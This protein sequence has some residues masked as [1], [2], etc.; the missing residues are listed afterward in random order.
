MRDLLGQVC[1]TQPHAKLPG[2]KVLREVGVPGRAGPCEEPGRLSA[3]HCGT[4]CRRPRL[5]LSSGGAIDDAFDCARHALDT[6]SKREE[7]IIANYG[8]DRLGTEAG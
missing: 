2:P 1:E 4:R 7:K 6:G 3:L 8:V 5:A